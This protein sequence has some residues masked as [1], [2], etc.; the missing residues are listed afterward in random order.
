MSRT[1]GAVDADYAIK[2]ARILNKL[3]VRFMAGQSQGIRFSAMAK[4]AGVSIPTLRHYFPS[5]SDV[6]SALLQQ[7]GEEGS[8]Y[9]A[10]FANGSSPSLED[11]LKE[12]G[13][14]IKQGV[15]QGGTSGIHAMGLNEGLGD[16]K[17]G[18][19][20]L[21]SILEPTL[22]ALETRLT[23]HIKKGEMK[24]CDVRFAALNFIAPI[25]VAY[26]HQG[27][28]GGTK[29]RPMQVDALVTEQIGTFVKAYGVEKSQIIKN[30]L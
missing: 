29:V 10:R 27:K 12:L 14:G 9:V 15:N 22:Q 23:K 8:F 30:K 6:L 7:L 16:A 24:S 28:L 19:S 11:T 21:Q 26:L 13:F 17:I 20:Y 2:R 25:L 1:K 5:R 18:P 3:R 4:I